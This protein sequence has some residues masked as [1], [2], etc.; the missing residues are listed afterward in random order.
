MQTLTC[1]KDRF[2]TFEA[3]SSEMCM[4]TMLEKTYPYIQKTSTLF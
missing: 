2:V 3:Y 4:Q 1:G